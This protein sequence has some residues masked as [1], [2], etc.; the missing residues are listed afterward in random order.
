MSELK[1][2]PFCGG[3]PE[4]IRMGTNRVSMVIGCEDCGATVESGETV[5]SKRS[6]WN[7]RADGWI[8]V[9][10]KLPEIGQ[11]CLI[12]IQVCDNFNIENGKYKGNGVWVGAWCDS[13]GNG[14]PYKVTRWMPRP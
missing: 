5:I 6:A 8:S 14:C 1:P 9:D 7:I 12:E 10:D 11:Q 4:L 13:R 2:C 3:K